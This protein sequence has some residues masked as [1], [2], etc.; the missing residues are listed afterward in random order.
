MA[1]V[2][3]FF[4]G[5]N[6]ITQTYNSGGYNQ[7]VGFTGLSGSVGNVV[8]AIEEEIDVTGLAGT[9]AVGSVTIAQGGGITV[10]VTGVAATG[11]A[12]GINIWG[13]IDDSQTP[14]WTEIAA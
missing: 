6:S 12:G 14:N 11:S 10:E 2:T 1:D 9:S 4:G 13:S 8:V 3:I 5:Y 7:D